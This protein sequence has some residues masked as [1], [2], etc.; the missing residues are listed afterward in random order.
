VRFPNRR[1]G[2]LGASLVAILAFWFSGLV[3]VESQ[4]AT[5]AAY[6]TLYSFGGF[7][8]GQSPFA[9]LV[10]YGGAYYGTTQAGGT[11]GSGTVYKMSASGE[12]RILHSFAGHNDGEAPYGGL[13][14][15]GGKLYGTTTFGGGTNNMGTVFEID[16][17]TGAEKVLHE[18]GGSPDGQYPGAGL[19]L[20]NGTLYGVAGGGSYRAGTV[21][22]ITTRGAEHIVYDFGSRGGGD[23][24]NPVGGLAALNGTLYGVTN[25]NVDGPNLYDFGTVFAV[26]PAG[27]ERVLHTFTGGADGDVPRGG[28]VAEGGALYGTT[29]YGGDVTG[30]NQCGVAF[31]IS[32]AGRFKALHEFGSMANDGMNPAA[33]LTYDNGTFYGTTSSGGTAGVGTVFAMSPAGRVRV[34]YS[35][36]QSLQGVR[37]GYAPYSALTVSGGEVLGTTT[38]GGISTAGTVFAV[39]LAGKERILHDF[40][41]F[42][43]GINPVGGL[44]AWNGTLY[45]T[46]PG[47]G[48]YLGGT[49]FSISTTGA[50]KV[51]HYFGNGYDGSDPVARPIAAAGLFY[52]STASGGTGQSGT[53]FSMTAAGAERV[54][55]TFTNAS[56]SPAVPTGTLLDAGGTFYGTSSRGGPYDAGA[57][58]EMNAAGKL[59]ILH[60]FGR[61]SDG[62][63]PSGELLLSNGVLYGTTAHGGGPGCG[64]IFELTG[65]TTERILHTFAGGDDGC[66]PNADLVELGGTLYGTTQGGGKTG[67]GTVFAIALPSGKERILHVFAGTPD[68][69]NPLG[70]LTAAAGELF[71]TTSAGGI[72]GTGP[73]AS[74]SGTIFAITTAGA[75]RV[76]YRFGGTPDGAF[77]SGDLTYAGGALYGT[78]Q[79]GGRNGTG[80]VYA[81]KP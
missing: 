4:A 28:L 29:N 9:G 50:E 17:V 16:P 15:A 67:A 46:T 48:P 37:D 78:T 77:P 38:A 40:I 57:A 76:V 51:L 62:T 73:Y 14:V 75:E 19:T 11:L 36:S 66:G 43:D 72:A 44:L 53:L 33:T 32:T 39:S 64:T 24:F 25:Q 55:D 68:G 79:I 70:G 23:G 61:G 80:S 47:G 69:A 49:L 30:C 60:Y 58:F 26:T 65:L 42:V 34:I 41:K 63:V 56:S 31:A 2:R 21:F 6:K 7:S 5:T 12:V 59:R 1:R 22:A 54:L 45:G 3:P 13:T 27:A 52:G 71:G 8:D 81:L 35:F 20:L 74:S 18:F 10:A